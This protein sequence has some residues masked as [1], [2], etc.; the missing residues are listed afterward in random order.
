MPNRVALH[1]AILTIAVVLTFLWVT[2]SLLANYTL[3]LTA[4]LVLALI[5]SRHLHRPSRFRLVE[6]IVSTICVLLV[7]TTTGGTSSPLFFLNHFLLFELSL[8][9]EP[10]IP[11]F[12][13]LAL[14]TFYL[15]SHQVGEGSSLLPLLSFPFMTPLAYYFGLIYNKSVNQHRELK[16]L[17]RRV[18][19]LEEE[20]VE[21]ELRITQ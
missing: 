1:L 4:V 17:S 21:G 14:I 11:M 15:F 20:L 5:A 7:T 12:L 9:L 10:A 16:N 3:Q 8:I 18:V 13:S 19:D 2:D 6:S